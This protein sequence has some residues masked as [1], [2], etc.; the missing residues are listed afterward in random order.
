MLYTALVA[1]FVSASGFASMQGQNTTG[2]DTHSSSCGI[3]TSAPVQL[4]EGY[5]PGSFD[6][7]VTGNTDEAQ[8]DCVITSSVGST[9]CSGGGGC[10]FPAGRTEAKGGSPTS[11]PAAGDTVTCTALGGGCTGQSGTCTYDIGG[12]CTPTS[13]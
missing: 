12:G 11:A 9:C 5:S 1:L 3:Q 4:P 7:V 8:V 10:N 6:F 13:V 2:A